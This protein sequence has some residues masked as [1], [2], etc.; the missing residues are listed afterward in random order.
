MKKLSS[1]SIICTLLFIL[2]E[3]KDLEIVLLIEKFRSFLRQDEKHCAYN[4]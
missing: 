3:A 1:V 2:S 4:L